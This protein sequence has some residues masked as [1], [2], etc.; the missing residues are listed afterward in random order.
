MHRA[1]AASHEGRLLPGSGGGL[2]QSACPTRGVG[3]LGRKPAEASR[4]R[5]VRGGAW[6]APELNAGGVGP[7]FTDVRDNR[8]AQRGDV[9]LLFITENETPG[10]NENI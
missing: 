2:A 7:G 3:D 1:T 5:G 9:F 4:R 6:S 8:G 10:R